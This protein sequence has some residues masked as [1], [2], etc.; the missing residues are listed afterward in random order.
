MK[1]GI[2]DPMKIKL[3]ALIP[4]FY[5][6]SC[7]GTNDSP[8]VTATDTLELK[9]EINW[10]NFNAAAFE[11]A[12]ENE[13]LLLLEVGANWCHW[14]HVMDDSTYS[15]ATVQSYLDDNFILCRADQDARP[16]LYA[17]YK[18]W[19][20]P[21]II[22]MNE[23][24][25]ELLR[26]RG[27][28]EKNEFLAD[29][30]NIRNDPIPLPDRNSGNSSNLELNETVLYNK[31]I[32]NIDLKKG[33]YNWKTKS[34]ESQGILH[35]LHFYK[36]NDTLK[37]WTDLTVKNSYQLVDPVWGGVYQYSAKKS[38]N[39]GHFE[40]ILR[41][42]AD[43]IN[44]Y[45]YYAAKTN[46]TEAIEQAKLILSYCDRFLGNETPLYWNSQN[47]DL[48]SGVHSGEYYD[49]PE[50]ERLAE[51]TP[52]VDKKIYL[53]EN[54]AMCIALSNLWAAT[55]DHSYLSKGQ[56]MLKFILSE[57]S[58]PAGLYSREIG[59]TDI[60]SFEDNRKLLD[61]LL[62]YYQITQDSTL[63][64]NATTLAYQ[65]IKRFDS[66]N[67]IQSA[68]GELAIVPTIVP[69]NNIRA[70]TTFN[71][72]GHITELDTF[73]NYAL[74]TYN[75]LNKEQLAKSQT[76]L[77]LS[78]KAGVEL[79]EA[80]FH[81]VFITDGQQQL[82]KTEY[83]SALLLNPNSYFIFDVLTLGEMTTEDEDF[84]GGFDAGTLFM[85]TA[86]FCS[87]PI[88]TKADLVEFLATQEM[89]L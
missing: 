21:A 6:F 45:C 8:N 63:L 79:K 65:L 30:K 36:S 25:D 71:L 73:K 34:L 28:Q 72:L 15:D 49:L 83:L 61:A 44:A 59:E 23:N 26:L 53:K 67:G 82:L 52:A 88:Y 16:D 76:T 70:V 38:W 22:V 14:C 47:A 80:P 50:A 78:F 66:P 18:P 35:G 1:Q 55:G 31:F 5:L 54:A 33:G 32:A 46:T 10:R 43:Y 57:Y 48:I 74:T 37:G 89:N 69:R 81:A 64:E 68:A 20:W 39:N 17:A 75:R 42:Q 11:K 60:Y 41:V 2:N 7:A 86:S 77:P 24:G 27:F 12:A 84:Y 29:L 9:T 51:G 40:K 13:K 62:R 4:L 3:I 56:N 58:T 85:C 19:G 87:S